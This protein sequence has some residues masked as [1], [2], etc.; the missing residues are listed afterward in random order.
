MFDLITK[1]K[2]IVSVLLTLF[3]IPF[4]FFGV[5]YYFRGG[6]AVGQVAKVGGASI[7]G[8][9]YQEALQQ[10]QDQLRRSL[11]GHAD[12]NLLNSPQVRSAVLNELV[13]ER[14]MYA[15]ALDSGVHVSNEQLQQV[16]ASEPQFREDAGKGPFSRKLY[17]EWLHARNMSEAGFEARV[18]KNLV[19]G[20]TRTA[21]AGSAFVPAT[22]LDR[23]YRLRGEQR[24]VSQQAFAPDE[25]AGKVK[26][27]PSEA[28]AYYDSHKAQYR[29]P[30]K[31]KVEYTL[32]SLDRVQQQVQVTPEQIKQYYEERR[33]QFETP[34]ERQVRHILVAVPANASAE[35]KATAKA[36]AEA[37]LGEVKKA[38]KSFPEIAKKSSED[39]GSAA[40]GG[41][42]GSFPR[43]SGLSKPFEDALFSAKA[44]DI[45]GPVETERGYHVIQVE[46][47]KAG[48][49]RPGF[50]A[51]KQQ[52]EAEL[53]K[54]E[55]GRRFAEAA[56]TFSNVVYEQPDSLEPVI[57]QFG[58]SV[59]KSGWISREGGAPDDPLLN[60]R[61]FLTA[62]FTDDVVKDHRNTEA[63]EIAPNVL[64]AARVTEHTDA[65][66]RP[67]AEVQADIIKQ[68]TREKAA[69]LA[70]EAG[71]ARL[72]QLKKGESA[73]TW[74]TAQ[75]VSRERLAG[76]QPDAARAV[77]SADAS[78]LPA[79]AGA[80][81][82]DRY[83]IYRITKL[84]DG[85]PVDPQQRKALAQQIDQAAA[86][87][88]DA[89]SLESLRKRIDVKI[90]QKAL[91]PNG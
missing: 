3:S 57:K 24:E 70:T 4:I 77:F 17:V 60:N 49:T 83:I 44:G 54:A 8:R 45:V 71:E 6:D 41:E 32:L 86:M 48:G 37:L 91:Q 11:E 72:A 15:A 82:G 62:V 52:A 59:Q 46:A 19:L 47:I 51:V 40:E 18:R 80:H 65:K 36:R 5:D 38:P 61:K 10:R 27:E 68:L 2:I 87:E 67:F 30:E 43:G 53:R 26:I 79:Y 29:V 25:F 63:V 23:L 20:R 42:L 84:V 90:N 28:Q 89:A 35:Q 73:G 58:L 88:A 74:S 66:D 7:S 76:L 21:L 50:E 55:A 1:H 81:V 12:A 39:P 31:V 14:L 13:N 56:E 22:V 69:K 34:E 78:K 9:E 33:S 64:V 75:L 16:I 85:P